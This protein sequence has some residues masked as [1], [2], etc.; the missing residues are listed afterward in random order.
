M[1]LKHKRVSH[2]QARSR[3]AATVWAQ[4]GESQRCCSPS[5]SPEDSCSLP[6]QPLGSVHSSRA[7]IAAPGGQ[8]SGMSRAAT[9]RAH[10]C[11]VGTGCAA[12]RVPGLSCTMCLGAL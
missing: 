2:S 9:S 6:P 1:E 10:K 12:H 5:L 4:P 11:L 7:G 8:S 3:R